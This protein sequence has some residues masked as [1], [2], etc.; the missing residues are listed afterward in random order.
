LAENVELDP[1]EK[2]A[3]L[4]LQQHRQALIEVLQGEKT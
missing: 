1:D 4:Q 3:L 2:T